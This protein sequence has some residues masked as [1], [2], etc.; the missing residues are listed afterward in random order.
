MVYGNSVYFFECLFEGYFRDFEF[1]FEGVH[2]GACV[3][4]RAPAVMTIRGSTFHPC[5][6][7]SLSRGWYLSI[8]LVMVFCEN[9]SFVYVNSIN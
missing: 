8:L 6:V 7:M 3:V 9:L 1:F 5:A 2:G 4:P